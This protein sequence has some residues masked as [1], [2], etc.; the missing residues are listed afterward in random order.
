MLS[1]GLIHLV[2]WVSTCVPKLARFANLA[3]CM[4]YIPLPTCLLPILFYFSYISAVRITI[5]NPLTRTF[6]TMTSP[7]KNILVTGGAGYI[8]SHT[9]LRLLEAGY[10][11][12]VVDNLV[13]SSE[14]SLKRVRELTGCD[15]SRIK[16]FNVD[17]CNIAA[18]EQ[19]FQSSPKFSACIHFAGLKA[20]GESVQ[21]PLLYY[22]NNIG[23]TVNLL[24]LMEKYEC[25]SI[26]F[27]SSATV[28]DPQ[29]CNLST[30]L[31][32]FVHYFSYYFYHFS[33]A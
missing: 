15:E 27:S 2:P 24:N 22:E 28:N 8:G 10:D 16:F 23:G 33:N 11:I 12:T 1:N 14:E 17:L 3:H 25:R 31:I 7:S 4:Q 26:V 19:V 20:V 29:I 13:N 30:R 21:K 18:L 6:L 32:S 9:I 5:N